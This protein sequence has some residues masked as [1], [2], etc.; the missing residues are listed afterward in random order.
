MPDLCVE[1]YWMCDTNISNVFTIKGSKGDE[2]RVD[3]DHRLGWT[4]SCKGF[5]FRRACKHIEQAKKKHCGWNEFIEGGDAVEVNDD[6][7][8]PNGR[9]CPKCGGM[10]TSQGWGV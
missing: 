9:A 10:V 3:Y 6:D 8:H 5:K 2:Y 1:Y 7:E 4:C